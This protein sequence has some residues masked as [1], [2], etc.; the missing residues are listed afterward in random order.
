MSVFDNS[1]SFASLL[2]GEAKPDEIDDADLYGRFHIT[3]EIKARAAAEWH[4]MDER[5][6][7]PDGWAFRG[8]V[9]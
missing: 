2:P 8:E 1:G 3:P 6:R 7:L 5:G 9:K 4:A